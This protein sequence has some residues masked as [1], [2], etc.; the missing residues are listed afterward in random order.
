M[1]FFVYPPSIVVHSEY[2]CHYTTIRH[3]CGT[4]FIVS[5]ANSTALLL[6]RLR[7]RVVITL[8]STNVHHRATAMG[9]RSDM[10]TVMLKKCHL[11]GMADRGT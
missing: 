2:Y 9:L 8:P 5:S 11:R 4:L 1:F 7:P 3:C 6:R 10:S